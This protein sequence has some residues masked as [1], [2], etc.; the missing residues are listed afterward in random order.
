MG[1]NP[2]GKFRL[3]RLDYGLITKWSPTAL[4]PGALQQA[5]NVRFDAQRLGSSVGHTRITSTSPDDHAIKLNGNSNY[6]RGKITAANNL[7]A[8]NTND[9]SFEFVFRTD[10][11]RS[12]QV[13]FHRGIG[14]A[15]LPAAAGG[16][17]ANDFA[18][19]S[20]DYA[21]YL[22]PNT[23]A[24][25]GKL[26]LYIWRRTSAGAT[27]SIP[28]GDLVTPLEIV[29]GAY[30]HAAAVRDNGAA[31]WTFYV[32]QVGTAAGA[33]SLSTAGAASAT[34]RDSGDIWDISVGGIGTINAA[35][36][37]E[38][39]SVG[40]FQG[41]IQ[42]L[43]I[44]NSVRSAANLESADDRQ[45]TTAEQA[46]AN[47]VAYYPLLGSTAT[48]R[49]F[50]S[51]SKGTAGGGAGQAPIL[52]LRP[53]AMTWISTSNTLFGSPLVGTGSGRLD[54]RESGIII[55]NSYRY[56]TG[57]KDGDS[58]LKHRD[59]YKISMRVKPTRAIDGATALHWV[60]VPSSVFTSTGFPVGIPA[61]G[62]TATETPA[63]SDGVMRLMLHDVGAGVL[64][65]TA[66]VWV[67]NAGT[68]E[69]YMVTS[70]V[71]G[72]VLSGTSYAVT[73]AY[74][75]S[76]N[77]WS[78]LVDSNAAVT[79][80][81]PAGHKILASPDEPDGS[82]YKY[83]MV[84]GRGI[85]QV[86][87]SNTNTFDP[88]AVDATYNFTLTWDGLID[89]VVIAGEAIQGSSAYATPTT[90][91]HAF[92]ATRE[93]TKANV[94]SLHAIMLSAWTFEDRDGEEIKDI[95]VVGNHIAIKEDPG[96][97]HGRSG[98]TTTFR[99]AIRGIFD[100]HYR[101]TTGPVR[102]RI[103]IAGGTVYEI[104][105]AY[106]ALTPLTDGF[107]NDD[108]RR[109]SGARY[110]DGL[111][112]ACGSKGGNY[113]LVEDQ[114][115]RAAIEPPSGILPFGLSDQI[116][117]KGKLLKGFYK[118]ALT[119]YSAITGKRSPVGIVAG[120]DIKTRRA[121]VEMGTTAEINQT[122]PKTSR[123]EAGGSF[124]KVAGGSD[125]KEP[126]DFSYATIAPNS[127]R[128][129]FAG[130]Y[131]T[132]TNL[133]STLNDFQED[134]WEEQ[135][136]RGA[137][138]DRRAKKRMA[139]F[140]TPLDGSDIKNPIIGN[141]E[142]VSADECESIV[143]DAA[144]DRVF[145]TQRE[146]G[147]IILN[148]CV[149]GGEHTD[150]GGRAYGAYLWVGDFNPA[151]HAAVTIAG[152]VIDWD[153]SA[154]A[155]LDAGT[156][157]TGTGT[158]SHGM[159]L[160]YSSDPQVT[161][162]EIW[163]TLADGDDFRLAARVENG[164][165]NWK[166]TVED[167]DLTG[168]ILDISIGSPPSVQYVSEVAGRYLWVAPIGNEQRAYFSNTA[169]PWEVPAQNVVDFLDG[170]SLPITGIAGIQGITAVFKADTLFALIPP[171]NP[172]VPF[173]IQVRYRDIGCLSH[174]GIVQCDG[175][176]VFPGERGFYVFDSSNADYISNVIEPTWHAFPGVYKTSMVGFWDRDRDTVNWG[177]ASTVTLKSGV[178]VPDVGASWCTTAP[179]TPE[180]DPTGWGALTGLQISYACAIQDANNTRR[181][182]FS[183][184]YGYVYEWGV[185]T[186]YGVGTLTTR[187][188]AVT[189]AGTTTFSVPKV[190]SYVTLPEGYRG[191]F[192]TWQNPTGG[193]EQRQV[194]SDDLGGVNASI[195]VDHA[196]SGLGPQVGDTVTFGSI[197]AQATFGEFSPG[198]PEGVHEWT[199]TWWR[200]VKQTTSGTW[201][202][203]WLGLGGVNSPLNEQTAAFS[204]LS[205]TQTLTGISN[206]RV[207]SKAA[208]A[209][210]GRRL[211]MLIRSLGADRPF[212]LRDMSWEV[213][214][215]NDDAFIP[216]T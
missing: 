59:E 159:K 50:F 160:P 115:Y 88:N 81:L 52:E 71:G 73:M 138:A 215:T 39:Y 182:F 35:S 51:P 135:P 46:N 72:G 143:T 199:S 192:V 141:I 174:F 144:K 198:G 124:W 1:M 103:A 131:G 209:A 53:A 205:P 161:H 175:R 4:P 96:H 49:Y 3:S 12:Y 118:Y 58:Q 36:R 153:V 169:R 63:T 48:S 214:P 42:E 176:L 145:L 45:L 78:L 120:V 122:Y 2:A 123:A 158:I 107:R 137:N 207:D 183:D 55:K 194:I 14:P 38:D 125:N 83:L 157:Y 191:F 34:M 113:H 152:G 210:R 5:A 178:G 70:N 30:Y 139:Y 216:V 75:R 201:D 98:I 166:D 44:W 22:R 25:N 167:E 91:F 170:T 172:L 17:P 200:Q 197:E 162:L 94:N 90:A 24:G 40:T 62:A 41:I 142:E 147:R 149:A 193:R 213:R 164:T 95:G 11:F 101:S 133:D 154:F 140:K 168:E 195:T 114:L 87:T 112:L 211:T 69:A 56:L 132:S 196:F 179:V 92:L 79:I 37:D 9:V 106:G 185:G 156:N 97:T 74:S 77:T 13:L 110:L 60:R 20:T 21:I 119:F 128:F 26:A 15:T 187:A 89:Q 127:G 27:E 10:T 33:G 67:D 117:K 65:F 7:F 76:A 190:T 151:T 31:R 188:V 85:E 84:L 148:S 99:R 212:M 202:M 177:I 104:P 32:H 23:T 18:I 146:D 19:G 171:S 93:V 121:T 129:R 208:T 61:A 181:V 155:S 203:L 189:V 66:I 100:H 86:R 163:R 109:I 64:Q 116:N 130:W 8:L 28:F 186:N 180:G 150:S 43:R 102:K 204:I 6:F 80:A 16:A 68:P 57:I 134:W 126:F 105:N 165:P 136:I 54:G 82:G 47:L 108:D 206:Q 184:E 29:P 173:D 111:L